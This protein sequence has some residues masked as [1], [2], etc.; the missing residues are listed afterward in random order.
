MASRQGEVG[1]SLQTERDEFAAENIRLRQ[2]LLVH[3]IAAAAIDADRLR[4]SADIIPG[5]G[6]AASAWR[7]PDA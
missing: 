2:I 7:C 6:Q 4:S 1:R 3:G 5:A